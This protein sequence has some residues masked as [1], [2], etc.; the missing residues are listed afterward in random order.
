MTTNC[1]EPA[2]N[3]LHHCNEPVTG[4]STQVR[5]G[6]VRLGKDRLDKVRLDNKKEDARGYSCLLIT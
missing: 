3:P 4:T 1:N 2:T 5:L 6:K